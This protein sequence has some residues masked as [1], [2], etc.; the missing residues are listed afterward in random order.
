MVTETPAARGKHQTTFSSS[1]SFLW[2]KRWTMA[3]LSHR[4]TQYDI[5]IQPV[6]LVRHQPW[7]RAS[8]RE[9]RIEEMVSEVDSSSLWISEVSRDVQALVLVLDLRPCNTPAIPGPQCPSQ[10][11]H[12]MWHQLPAS[13]MCNELKIAQ[14]AV[15]SRPGQQFLFCSVIHYLSP[16][17]ICH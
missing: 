10:H 5:V 14:R 2:D 3:W 16:F 4:Q 9:K 6:L 11:G 17:A 13:L 7:I 1:G 8:Q 12:V 15:L